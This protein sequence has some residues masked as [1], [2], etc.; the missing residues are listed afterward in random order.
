MSYFTDEPYSMGHRADQAWSE[1]SPPPWAAELGWD[2]QGIWLTVDLHALMRS[3]Q[4]IDICSPTGRPAS[5]CLGLLPYPGFPLSN[6]FVALENKG[7][8][9][10]ALAADLTLV[11][12]GGVIS[13]GLNGSFDLV[14]PMHARGWVG[15]GDQTHKLLLA[16]RLV[17]TTVPGSATMGTPA[18]V[19][20]PFE[21]RC[22]ITLNSNQVQGEFD[23]IGLPN[24]PADLPVFLNDPPQTPHL[25]RT[26]DA[27]DIRPR[28]SFLSLARSFTHRSNRLLGQ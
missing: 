27:P 28:R 21:V 22:R 13:R 1:G 25:H 11:F 5:Q 23:P 20:P 7:L 6:F 2:G 9:V 14:G 24:L 12:E 15:P 4:S 26:L 17:L 10:M 3:V 8:P 18:E 19:V 16:P